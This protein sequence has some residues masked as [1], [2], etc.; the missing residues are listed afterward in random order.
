[1]SKKPNR[2]RFNESQRCE[3]IAKLSKTN[4]PIKRA[5]AHEYDVN[6]RAIRK[7]WDK[8]EQILE[9]FALMCDEA[10]KKTFRSSIGHFTELENMF[11]I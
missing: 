8:R 11:Y 2:K 3:I 10:K 9:Q 1:M 6:E 7:V 4:A 5:I